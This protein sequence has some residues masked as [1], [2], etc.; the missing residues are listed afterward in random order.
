MPLKAIFGIKCNDIYN[1]LRKSNL[2]VKYNMS[3]GL[4]LVKSRW[5]TRGC[6]SQQLLCNKIPNP[7]WFK[8]II[9]SSLTRVW[10]I[11][12]SLGLRYFWAGLLH[13]TQSLEGLII[14]ATFT[15]CY[16]KSWNMHSS[17]QETLY[18]P[19]LHPTDQ[20]KLHDQAQQWDGKTYFAAS[21]KNSKS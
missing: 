17:S 20:D 10:V 11:W 18:K 15:L 21:G 14:W 5:C 6:M 19:P 7:E 13:F 9:V 16:G 12:W 2:K 4:T 8:R 3:Q 1:L